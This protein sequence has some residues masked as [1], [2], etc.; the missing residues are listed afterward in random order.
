M[1]RYDPWYTIKTVK[2]PDSNVVWECFTGAKGGLHFLPKKA[3]NYIE[4][5]REHFALVCG[6]FMGVNFLCKIVPHLTRPKV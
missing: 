1:S 5:L 4:V 2:H 3:N 6:K